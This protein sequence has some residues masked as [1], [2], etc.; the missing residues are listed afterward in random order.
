MTDPAPLTAP[1]AARKPITRTF[2]GRE[3]VDDYEWLRDKESQD[4][5]DY[6][7]AENAYT[8]AATAAI[9]PLAET[10]YQEIKSRVKETDMSV[11]VRAGD[12]WYYGRTEEGKD[13]GY[14]CRLPVAEGSDPWTPP[15]LPEDGSAPEGEEVIL[16]LNQLAEGHDF[17]SLGAST[18]TTSGRYLAYSVDTS[19]DERFDLH[20]K[21]L[22]TGELLDDHLG[23]IFYGATWVGEDY[24]FYQRVDDAWRPDT[25]W[26]HKIGTPAT[27]DV[28]VYRE[29]DERYNVSDGGVR[30]EKYLLIESASKVTT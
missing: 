5:L 25:V 8:D 9:K 2:H 20:V 17:I 16:D 1:V 10:I 11:P 19:G 12:W 14:S 6:L 7:N 22:T 28:L 26:R 13:Y 23:G 18:V 30:S 4:T 15:V 27:E 3:F 21:D 24:I 29:E